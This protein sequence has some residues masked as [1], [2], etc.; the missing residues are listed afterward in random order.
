MTLVS[1]WFVVLVVFWTG[2][3]VLEGFDFGVGMLHGV[4]GRDERG[5]RLA[6][7]TIGPLWDGNEVW[8]IVAAA[9]TF[10]AFPGWYA[11]MFSGFYLAFLL[12]LVALIARGVSFEFYGKRDSARWRRAWDAAT[13]GGS[14]LAP[15]LIGVALGNLLHGVPIGTD[16]EYAGT[17]TDL[18]NPYSLFTGVT[19]VLLCLLHGASFLTLKTAGEVR[20]RALHTGRRVAP[21]AAA[22]VLGFAVWTQVMAGEGLL[23]LLVEVVAVLAAVAAAW[24]LGRGRDGRAF[25]ATSLAMAAV[26]VSIFVNLYPRVMVSTLGSSTDLTVTNTSSAPYSLKVMTVAAA[27]LFPIV[28]AY[29]GWTYYV[30]R[31]RVG[32]AGATADAA[33]GPAG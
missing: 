19:V 12:L 22:A 11:T 32:D 10:A 15:L 3:L 26:V 33:V 1:F 24:L 30:F 18:L 13:T 14:L 23:A 31:R 20:E 27:V 7:Q 5:R 4:V 8:L 16:Q 9:G 21:V 6:I 28:L 2:F 17:F 29:Q 25:A